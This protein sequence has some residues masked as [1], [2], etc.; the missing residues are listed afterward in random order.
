MH[1]LLRI[2]HIGGQRSAPCL[3]ITVVQQ[4]GTSELKLVTGNLL[5]IYAAANWEATAS[6]EVYLWSLF[7]QFTPV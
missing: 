4:P 7:R 5:F 1:A 2:C 6:M 3:L